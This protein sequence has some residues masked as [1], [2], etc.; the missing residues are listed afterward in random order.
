MH[1]ALISK[2]AEVKFDSQMERDGWPCMQS[3]T[4]T[5]KF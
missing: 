4:A 5:E 1:A 3:E 2:K